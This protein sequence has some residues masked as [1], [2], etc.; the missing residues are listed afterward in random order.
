MSA[1]GAA[2]VMT[3]A[4]QMPWPK[5]EALRTRVKKLPNLRF[6]IDANAPRECLSAHGTS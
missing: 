3:V 1:D 5:A 2:S 4:R 6:V